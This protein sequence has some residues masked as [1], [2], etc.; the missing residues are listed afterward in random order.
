MSI[1]LTGKG[2]KLSRGD[3]KCLALLYKNPVPPRSVLCKLKSLKILKLWF[4]YPPGPADAR[5]LEMSEREERSVA[6][7]TQRL[8]A[9]WDWRLCPVCAGTH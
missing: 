8:T 3:L 7:L 5:P 4:S 9:A 1:S 6:L 2:K